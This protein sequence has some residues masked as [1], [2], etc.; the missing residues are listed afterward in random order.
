MKLNLMSS[1][2]DNSNTE[3]VYTLTE[4]EN[5][6]RSILKQVENERETWR[7]SEKSIPLEI[8]EELEG[9][10]SSQLQDNFKRFKTDTWRY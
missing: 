8:L 4:M 10:S 2:N 7:L 5:M 1:N 9:T 6:I 3:R